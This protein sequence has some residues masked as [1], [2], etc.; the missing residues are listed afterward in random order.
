MDFGCPWLPFSFAPR[1]SM[2]S[3]FISHEPPG[4]SAFS[5]RQTNA[6]S[7]QKTCKSPFKGVVL[8]G[9]DGATSFMGV[10]SRR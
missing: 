3:S 9:I 10:K 8:S 1:G 7:L 5:I 6:G 4:Q 2:S